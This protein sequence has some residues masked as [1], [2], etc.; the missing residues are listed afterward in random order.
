MAKPGAIS[1]FYPALPPPFVYVLLLLKCLMNGAGLEHGGQN[2]LYTTSQL[3]VYCFQL[4]KFNYFPLYWFFF[5]DPFVG[6]LKS[7]YS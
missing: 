4:L 3:L 7:P 6:L 5:R 2:S 1:S